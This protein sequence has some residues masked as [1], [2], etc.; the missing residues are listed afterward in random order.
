MKILFITQD[1]PF[2]IKI[3]F[4]TFLKGYKYHDEIQGVVICRTMG[5]PLGKLI[6]QMY[7]FY[8]L[9]DF[10]RMVLR[11]VASKALSSFCAT[12]RLKR[13]FDLRQ[14]FDYYNIRI[15]ST[16]DIN[17]KEFI[18]LLKGYNLDLI[19]SVA[20]PNIF[21]ED[22]LNMPKYGCINIHIAKLP[23]YKGMMPNFW[24][25]YN[26]EKETG[27]TIHKM[28]SGIDEG[29]II[30]QKAVEIYPNES[31]DMLIKRTKQIGAEAMIEVVKQYEDGTVRYTTNKGGKGSYFTFPTREDVNKFR[32]RGKRLL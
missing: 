25:L 13:F 2:Y 10:C 3:F 7:D 19:V 29:E 1:D 9:R 27:I 8:G 22:L 20:C 24:N 4:E 21:K 11:Y 30:L 18:D 15:I 17:D 23:Q 31:L 12:L 6:K 5:K 14:V 26:N 16:T 28:N 32:R